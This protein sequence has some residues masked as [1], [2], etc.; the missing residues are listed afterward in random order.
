MSNLGTGECFTCSRNGCN[1]KRRR[2]ENVAAESV[3]AETV[4][5]EK[6]A[7]ETEET[8]ALC[9]HPFVFCSQNGIRVP[10]SEKGFLCPHCLIV[11]KLD[12]FDTC[13]DNCD[14]CDNQPHWILCTPPNFLKQVAVADLPEDEKKRILE[15]SE[16]VITDLFTV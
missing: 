3:D 4:V 15:F 12:G 10:Y 7:A 2:R 16:E 11:C 13:G 14:G 1:R 9:D 8:Q 5:A 6:K